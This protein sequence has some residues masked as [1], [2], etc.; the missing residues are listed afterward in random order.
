[1]I[2]VQDKTSQI[3][4][5]NLKV[6]NDK[7]KTKNEMTRLHASCISHDM[8]APLGAINATIDAVL[9]I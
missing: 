3:A 8:K 1:M 4:L 6:K 9:N 5:D 7:L 2:I